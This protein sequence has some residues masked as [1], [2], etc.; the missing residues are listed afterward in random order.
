LN[1]HQTQDV[2][3]IGSGPAGCATAITLHRRGVS[4]VCIIDPADNP[5]LRVGETLPPDTRLILQELGLWDGFL[6]DRHEPCLGTC[7]SWGSSWLGYNDFLLSPYGLGW[8]LDRRR[9]DS[10][11]LSTAISRGIGLV[12]AQVIGNYFRNQKGFQLSLKDAT[13]AHSTLVTRFVVDATGIQSAF[14]RRVGAEPGFLDRLMFLCGLFDASDS[15]SLLQLT[16]L[17][18]AESGWWY[19]A[20]IPKRKLAV[21]FATDPEIVRRDTLSREDRWFASLLRTR[22][23]AP[24]LE[25]CRLLRGNFNIRVAPSFLLDRVAGPGWLA[26]GDAAAAYDPISSQGIHKAVETGLKAGRALTAALGSG[27]EVNSDYAG[28]ILAGFEEYRNNRNYFYRL[29]KQWSDSPFWRRR[30]ERTHLQW[31]HSTA[32]DP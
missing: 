16:M 22:H 20:P 14:A 27:I 30:R 10:F 7:A 18:A 21:A 11:L 6:S 31:A 8:H 32:R 26:V 9:F 13:G 25:G 2:A 24:R 4:R 17:E 12:R 29:E 1:F 5:G 3:I 23:I 19:A 28:S 15:L